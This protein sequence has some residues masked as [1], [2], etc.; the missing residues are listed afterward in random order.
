[1]IRCANT[2]ISG[3]V[4]FKGEIEKLKNRGKE[5]FFPGVGNFKIALNNKRSFYNRY[6]Q[7]L[8]FLCSIFLLGV[9]LVQQDTLLG[10]PT[11]HPV[12]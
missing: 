5:V 7:T 9:V 6:P 4:S 11:G 2:G 1:I 8:I 3:W 12:G 10:S